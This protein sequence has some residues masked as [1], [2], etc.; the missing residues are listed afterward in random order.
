MIRWK[1]ENPQ[2]LLSAVKKWFTDMYTIKDLRWSIEH[3]RCFVNET[4]ERFASFPLKKG[5]TIA[6][7]PLKRPFFVKESDRIL[8]EDEHLLVYD[9]PPYFSSEEIARYL[10]CFLVHRLDRDT[11]GVILLAK[12]SAAKKEL[13]NGFRNRLIDKR[14][15]AVVPR[16]AQ[17]SGVITLKIK[18]IHRRDGLVKWGI[19]NEGISSET[20]W[21]LLESI[22]SF[23]LLSCTPITGRT[24]QIRVH[25]A[26]IGHPVIGDYTYGLRTCSS[27]FRPLLHAYR[28]E[29]KHPI[30]HQKLSFRAPIPEDFLTS[31]FGS[32]LKKNENF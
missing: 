32:F 26:H 6:M 30:F 9:K 22:A 11:T 15:L 23:S 25:L 5:D 2:R 31:Q 12:S 10:N 24:H 28:M 21:R 3:N 7:A 16:L 20:R 18:Q 29:L 19:A 13:E 17:K 1:V 27:Y 8:F 4:V 14:Y